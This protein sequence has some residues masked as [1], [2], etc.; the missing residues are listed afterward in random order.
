VTAGRDPSIAIK[1]GLA[2]AVALLCL[3][4][5]TYAI[6]RPSGARFWPFID[7]PMF[8][9]SYPEGATF[10]IHQLR[11]VPCSGPPHAATIGGSAIGY[12][13]YRYWGA[14]RT[15][16][17][18][19]PNAPQVRAQLNRAVAATVVPPP[20]TLQVWERAITVT[21][22]GRSPRDPQWV[23]VREWT[24]GDSTSVRAIAP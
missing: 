11:G 12:H 13:H 8:S 3:A 4:A 10:R 14:L 22:A 15:V 16:A 23:L 5:Q 18:D 21:R 2:A 17:A 24:L 6:V 1:K 9:R 7:Y 19:R 20:C